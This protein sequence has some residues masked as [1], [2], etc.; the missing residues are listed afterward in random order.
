MR[1]HTIQELYELDETYNLSNVSK[2]VSGH[3]QG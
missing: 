1:M 2:V 3:V